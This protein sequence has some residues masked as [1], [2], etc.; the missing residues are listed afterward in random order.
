MPTVSTAAAQVNIAIFERMVC[1]LV[2]RRTLG[3]AWQRHSQQE[4]A[5]AVTAVTGCRFS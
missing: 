5:A 1:L 4:T 3:P 2:L